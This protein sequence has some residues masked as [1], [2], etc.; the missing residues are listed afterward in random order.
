ME[1]IIPLARTHEDITVSPNGRYAYLTGGYLL[2]EG[3]QGLTVVDLQQRT[4][5][6]VTISG[7]PLDIVALPLP[8]TAEDKEVDMEQLNMALIA[9]ARQGNA[10]AVKSLLSRGASGTPVTN[11]G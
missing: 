5:S 10:E 3:W 1:E 4:F 7:Y 8:E 9:A 2:G 6:E 11:G